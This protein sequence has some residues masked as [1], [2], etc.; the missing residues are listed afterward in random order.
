VPDELR[1]LVNLM[2]E[3]ARKVRSRHNLKDLN[4][5]T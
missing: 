2:M 3:E 1:P 5:M 4:I